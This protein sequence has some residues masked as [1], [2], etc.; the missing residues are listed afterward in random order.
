MVPVDHQRIDQHSLFGGLGSLSTPA[1]RKHIAGEER[2]RGESRCTDSVGSFVSWHWPNISHLK[3]AHELNLFELGG[4][5]GRNPF[6]S[7]K[8][9]RR[10]MQSL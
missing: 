3:L 7:H 8:F 4:A 2:W 1:A 10:C 6:D 5:T 9:Q